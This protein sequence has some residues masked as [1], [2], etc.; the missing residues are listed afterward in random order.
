MGALERMASARWFVKVP[1][2]ATSRFG[3]SRL[4]CWLL[5][6]ILS[7][8]S[9]R[10]SARALHSLL[11]SRG[12]IAHCLPLGWCAAYR[13]RVEYGDGPFAH[14]LGLVH[15]QIRG[16]NQLLGLLS[17]TQ[18]DADARRGAQ[19]VPIINIGGGAQLLLEA[20]GD[21]YRCAGLR[22]VL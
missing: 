10:C 20:F 1:S 14:A 18:G 13:L 21:P 17:G 12:S 2:K 19:P 22:H 11:S 9:R 3:S 5:R 16:V 6:S 8:R 7:L 4:S 15:R